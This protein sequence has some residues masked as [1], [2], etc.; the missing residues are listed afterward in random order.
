MLPKS[1]S[2]LTLLELLLVAAIISLL[3]SVILIIIDPRERILEARDSQVKNDLGFLSRS[4]EAYYSEKG[5]V[6]SDTLDELVADLKT[7]PSP[8][9]GWSPQEDGKY[10]YVKVG[11]PTPQSA[12]IV[13][14]RLQSK[15]ELG[16]AQDSGLTC[17]NDSSNLFWR[18]LSETRRTGYYCGSNPETP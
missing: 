13:Y 9:P 3:A 14:T 11:N 10:G 4:L 12:I 15:H 18:Y 17:A 1:Q 7:V 8:P 5:S 2:G 16:K 6:Y